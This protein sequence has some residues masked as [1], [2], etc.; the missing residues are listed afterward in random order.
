[1]YAHHWQIAFIFLV[2]LLA[3]TF[4]G[5]AGGGGGFIMLPILVAL[6]LSPQQAVAT[7]KLSAFGIGLG[8]IAAFRKKSFANPRLLLFLVA[9]AAVISL[10][11]PHIFRSLSGKSFQVIM[12]LIIL[13]LIPAVLSEKSGMKQQKKSLMTKTIGTL[14]IIGILF[15]QGVFS[16]GL[17]SLSNV[18]LISFF[19]LSTLQANAMR[20]VITLALNTFIVITLIATTHFIIY[21]LALAGLAGSFIGGYTGSHI[22]LEKGER[23]A[24]Y[25]LAAFMAVSGVWLLLTAG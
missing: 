20:R 5:M 2:S 22:A 4:S 13:A 24:K 1:M 17:G 16:G 7:N 19:G 14:L 12:A 3:S 9:I 23:F 10:F 6:G 18:M 21:K 25:A 11:V 15:L 8:S